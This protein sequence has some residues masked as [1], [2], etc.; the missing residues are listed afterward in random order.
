MDFR[1]LISDEELIEYTSNLNYS[2]GDDSELLFPVRKVANPIVTMRSIMEGGN[3]DVMAYVH[4]QDSEARIGNRNNF[5]EIK[6]ETLLVKEK[7][8]TSERLEEMLQLN[9]G[10]SEVFDFVF[11]D[12]N[13]L[14]RRILV[15]NKVMR[16]ELLSSGLITVKENNI[17]KTLDYKIPDSHRIAISEWD[18]PSHDI[19]A[20][21]EKIKTFAIK[22]GYNI[23]RAF[24]STT[25]VNYM[26][27]N[28]GVRA[29]WS[30][31]VT[32]LTQA[33]LLTWLDNN[34]GI[35]F[36]TN[37]EVYKTDALD[38]E[39]HRY[40]DENTITWLTTD[41]VLGEGLYGIT[42]EQRISL[43]LP[44]VRE[45]MLV[46]ITTWAQPDP[47]IVWTKGSSVYLPVIKDINGLFI[48]KHTP[49]T[50]VSE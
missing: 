1:S 30:S 2:T 25:M 43:K 15:R 5:Q 10:K 14:V 23:V 26:L 41:G 29:F 31:S 9:A 6:L 21:I 48:S 44:D 20:D 7:L 27:A 16:W 35:E 3:I 37:D 13:T 17:T 22:S 12:V 28:E 50:S 11:N 33:N 47:A 36:I 39:S 45:N 38:S 18:D 42:P 40:F 32:P 24:T 49:K 34:Y 8:P 4:A 46:T 19:L